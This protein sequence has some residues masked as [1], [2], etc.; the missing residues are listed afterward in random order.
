MQNFEF[1]RGGRKCSV[2]NDPFQP[3][4]EFYSALIE[5]ADGGTERVDFSTDNWDG[6]PAHC[7]GH[8]RQRIPNLESG[9]VYWAPDSVLLAYFEHINEQPN[10]ADAAFVMAILLQQKRILTLKNQEETESGKFMV[11]L[12]R[13]T[14]EAYEVAELELDP[15]QTQQ[16]QDELSEQLFSDQPMVDDSHLQDAE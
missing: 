6:P 15:A 9:K 4:D 2:S 14:N 7:I 16:I 3:G 11:L 12:N 13:K 10:K 8:W 1:K 5:L